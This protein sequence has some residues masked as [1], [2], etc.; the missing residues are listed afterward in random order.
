M[1]KRF[2]G[3]RA[4][5]EDGVPAPLPW[6]KSNGFKVVVNEEYEKGKAENDVP[7]KRSGITPDNVHGSQDDVH[8]S[9]DEETQQ[10]D[11]KRFSSGLAVGSDASKLPRVISGNDRDL[12]LSCSKS[13]SD[14]FTVSDHRYVPAPIVSAG[15][16]TY[17]QRKCIVCRANG[18]RRD[19][20]YCCKDCVGMPAL[21][22]S[23]CFEKHHAA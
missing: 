5:S 7:I 20:G 17:P 11:L 1:P 23:P 4:I 2:N 13:N 10:I 21:C 15:K 12:A 14:V 3:F 8:G 16:K 6:K 18:V 22:K 9:S 19:T